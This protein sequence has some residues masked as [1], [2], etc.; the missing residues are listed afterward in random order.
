ME[1]DFCDLFRID[2]L[3]IGGGFLENMHLAGVKTAVSAEDKADHADQSKQVQIGTAE[4][5]NA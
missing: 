5:L 1:R 4:H 2:R 3:G